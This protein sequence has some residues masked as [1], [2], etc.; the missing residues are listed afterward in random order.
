MLGIRKTWHL[1]ESFFC[2]P[3]NFAADC[4][5]TKPL[6]CFIPM[7]A[8]ESFSVIS[9]ISHELGTLTS[10]FNC[11]SI[12]YLKM[13]NMNEWAHTIVNSIN[14]KHINLQNVSKCQYKM[15]T[16]IPFFTFYFSLKLERTETFWEIKW[17]KTVWIGQ[18]VIQNFIEATLG[19]RLIWNDLICI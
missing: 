8:W 14:L 3:S 12:R 10:G 7:T 16:E 11:T 19:L 1:P 2:S 5:E 17:T 6:M 13:R 15:N 18:K 4:W 9:K